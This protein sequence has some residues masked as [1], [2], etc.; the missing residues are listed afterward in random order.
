M[1]SGAGPQ[2]S[3]ANRCLGTSLSVEA[4]MRFVNLCPVLQ[5]FRFIKQKPKMTLPLVPRSTVLFTLH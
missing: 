5:Y 1:S 2:D 3:T 4:E